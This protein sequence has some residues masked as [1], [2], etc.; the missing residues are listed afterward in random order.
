M[1]GAIVVATQGITVLIRR[2]SLAQAVP[3][4]VILHDRTLLEIAARKPVDHA[5]LASIAGIG[6]AKLARYGDTLL[7]LISG[8]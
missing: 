6:N 3:A 5:A 7:Q 2:A 1:P 8:G 4:F